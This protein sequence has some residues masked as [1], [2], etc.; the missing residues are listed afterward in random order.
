MYGDIYNTKTG[1][2]YPFSL[3]QGVISN[4]TSNISNTELIFQIFTSC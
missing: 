3:F 4:P 2:P 1:M